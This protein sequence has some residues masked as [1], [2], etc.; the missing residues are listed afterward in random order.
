[1]RAR[2]I[3][4][5]AFGLLSQHF[6]IFYTPI[7]LKVSVTEN[8]IACA[9]ILQN[10]IIDER[11]VPSDIGELSNNE[12]QSLPVYNDI[13]ANSPQELKF[14]IRDTFKEYF[15]SVGSVSWQNDAFRL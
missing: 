5:N 13:E 12:L 6:R 15:N 3:V 14:K 8:L 11:G 2:R 10:L 4:E 7:N 9:C 1:M